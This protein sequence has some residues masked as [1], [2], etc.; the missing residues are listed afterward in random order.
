MTTSTLQK[1]MEVATTIT[2][3]QAACTFYGESINTENELKCERHRHLLLR[4]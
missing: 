1:I 2:R 3:S 4:K